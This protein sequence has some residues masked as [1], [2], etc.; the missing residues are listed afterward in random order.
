MRIFASRMAAVTVLAALTLAGCGGS[1][2]DSDSS[3]AKDSSSAS[4]TTAAPTPEVDPAT[5]K[6]IT[7]K[8]YTYSA[9]D[10]WDV[11]TQKIPGTEMTD[12]FVA[13]LKD[14]DGF[15]DNINVIKQD[16]TPPKGARRVQGRA[17]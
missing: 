4:K 1:D 9:P 11:P 3:K 13:D 6:T 14:T 8:G 12:S 2:S 7:G 10:G 16:T 17:R 5:G 15:A